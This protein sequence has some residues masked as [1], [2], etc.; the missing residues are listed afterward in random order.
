MR[1]RI[2]YC[3]SEDPRPQTMHNCRRQ[4]TASRQ[5]GLLPA[6]GQQSQ[7]R[8]RG[9][10]DC[11]VRPCR[12]VRPDHTAACCAAQG[13]R[14]EHVRGAAVCDG[15]GRGGAALPARAG[16]RLH[17]H[18]LLPHRCACRAAPCLPDSHPATLGPHACRLS[19]PHAC[20]H[21]PI[22]RRVDPCLPPLP[23]W[24][25][26]CWALMQVFLTQIPAGGVQGSSSPPRTSSSCSWS[27][28]WPSPCSPTWASASSSS[29]R[30]RPL[31][32][33]SPLVRLS[34]SRFCRGQAAQLYCKI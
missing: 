22:A 15:G 30:A 27:S 5:K 14:G 3:I 9:V 28:S 7:K 23:A 6:L 16:H 13:A 10:L 1:S 24:G 26:G 8:P 25:D 21:S 29:R 32:R 34:R 31:R 12:C 18:L 17:P 20:R 2:M 4:W 11:C 19:R 33:S